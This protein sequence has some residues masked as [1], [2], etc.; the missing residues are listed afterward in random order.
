M[1]LKL[2]ILMLAALEATT[3][4]TLVGCGGAATEAASA[5]AVN[6]E[7]AERLRWRAIDSTAPTI[8]IAGQTSGGTAGVIGL[9]GR[10]TDNMRLYRVAWQND[11]GGQGAATMEGTT[12]DSAWT[13]ATIQLQPGANTITVAARTRRG[14]LQRPPRW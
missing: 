12:T 14:T 5:D 9:T 3:V 2:N 7:E 4:L 13:A 6:Q 10:A 11:R 8:A 1:K